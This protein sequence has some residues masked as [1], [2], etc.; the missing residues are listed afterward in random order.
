MTL[1]EDP[2]LSAMANLRKTL[3]RIAEAQETMAIA[4]GRMANAAEEANRLM[5][6]VAKR[7]GATAPGSEHTP[8]CPGWHPIR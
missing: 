7:D 4:L 1:Y 8:L 3:M 5:A 6:L 2:M